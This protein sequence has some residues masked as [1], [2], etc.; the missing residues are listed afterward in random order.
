MSEAS[1]RTLLIVDDA[2]ANLTVLSELLPPLCRVRATNS[3]RSALVIA[4]L[5]SDPP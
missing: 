2:A 5:H 1:L 4:G 3:G